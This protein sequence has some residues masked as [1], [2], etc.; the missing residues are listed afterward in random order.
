MSLPTVL[1][2]LGVAPQHLVDDQ[3]RHAERRLSQPFDDLRKL[4]QLLLRRQIEDGERPRNDQALPGRN[5]CTLAF[6]DEQR[7][8][9]QLEGQRNAAASPGPSDN[10]IGGAC[11]ATTSNHAGGDD[12]QARTAMGA[13][14]CNSSVIT[15]GGAAT[16]PN[17]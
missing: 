1:A 6:V 7:V 9:V 5:G 15:S 14:T 12:A 2:T 8:S 3:F 16:R 13:R 11:V 4:K 10:S 17:N